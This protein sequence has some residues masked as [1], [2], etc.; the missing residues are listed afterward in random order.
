MQEVRNRIMFGSSCIARAPVEEAESAIR[1]LDVEP[2]LA[3]VRKAL[4]M[5]REIRE[6][7]YGAVLPAQVISAEAGLARAQY[8][9]ATTGSGNADAVDM[10]SGAE[11]LRTH[12]EAAMTHTRNLAGEL[13][14]V[15]GFLMGAE[16]R[17]AMCDDEYRAAVGAAEMA[18]EVQPAVI[19]Y[20]DAYLRNLE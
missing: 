19:A 15:I 1:D 7:A 17:L 9:Q 3:V 13:G 2:S 14:P 8:E 20:A 6:K 18:S 4:A 12:G 10:V 5:L 16:Q 11:A